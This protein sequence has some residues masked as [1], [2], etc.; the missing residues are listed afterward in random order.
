MFAEDAD[1]SIVLATG[2]VEEFFFEADAAEAFAA[3]EEVNKPM[4]VM[5]S[6]R[7]E[8]PGTS[9]APLAHLGTS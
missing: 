2:E 9:T 3:E 6:K 5:T 8:D 7:F 1:I 4:P